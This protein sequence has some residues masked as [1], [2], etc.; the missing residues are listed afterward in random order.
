MI[1][2]LGRARWIVS[3]MLAVGAT[4]TLALNVAT[5]RAALAEPSSQEFD[6]RD[7][8]Y[9]F[10]TPGDTLGPWHAVKLDYVDSVADD[11]YIVRFVNGNHDDRG[12]PLHGAFLRLETYHRFNRAFELKLAA[13][14]GFGYQ[15]LRSVTLE[16]DTA[17]A[18]HGRLR[19]AVGEVATSTNDITFQRIFAVGPDARIGSCSVYARY[20]A[21]VQKAPNRSGPGTLAFNASVPIGASSSAT[22]YANFGGEV[23]GDRTASQLPTSSGR[24]GPDV[25]LL[26]KT[27]VTR[28]LGLLLNYEEASY[29]NS[30][31]GTFAYRDR[32]FVI[33]VFVPIHS[34]PSK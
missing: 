28:G 14:A 12:R 25:G 34:S 9:L 3:R 33:G 10:D 24:F 20:Y 21:P 16:T 23:G 30:A 4:M 6:L 11:T 26:L 32:V 31:T 7:Y 29:H 19:F 2:R 22:A 13:G 17:L 27:S 18:A 5:P 8:T 15:P 1:A